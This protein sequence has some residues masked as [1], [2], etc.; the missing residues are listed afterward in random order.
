MAEFGKRTK[1]PDK[2]CTEC[3]AVHSTEYAQYPTRESG[4]EYCESCGA[5]LD[6]WSSTAHPTYKL[7]KPD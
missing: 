3:G 5:V 2:T 7:K 6:K 4:I 1:G